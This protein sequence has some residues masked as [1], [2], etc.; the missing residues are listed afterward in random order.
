MRPPRPPYSPR[1]GGGSAYRSTAYV[2]S[3]PP[4][5]RPPRRVSFL[6]APPPLHVPCSSKTV[7]APTESASLSSRSK[8]AARSWR[9][10]EP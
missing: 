1:C 7:S 10:R 9:P 5:L 3:P 4:P 2:V 6:S 8:L